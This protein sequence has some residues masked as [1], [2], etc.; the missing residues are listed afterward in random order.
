MVCI[1]W[2]VECK[3]RPGSS[4]LTTSLVTHSLKFKMSIGTVGNKLYVPGAAG[5]GGRVAETNPKKNLLSPYSQTNHVNVF[6]D[7]ATRLDS[8]KKGRFTI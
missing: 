3:P 2:A 7:N 5:G 6:F 1:S 8:L 4:K